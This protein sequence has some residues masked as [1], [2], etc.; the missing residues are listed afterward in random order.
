MP[1]YTSKLRLTLP[2]TGA[3]A[4]MWGDLV[5]TG[6]TP[7]IEDA[8]SGTVDID[9]SGAADYTLSTTN[10]DADESRNMFLHLIGTPGGTFNVVC[11]TVSK[12]YFVRNDTDAAQV[13]KTVA[14]SGVTVPLGAT[15]ALYCDGTDVLVAFNYTVSRE[16]PRVLS[17]T[18]YTTDTGTSLNCDLLD[19]FIVTAQAGALK[20]NNPTGTPT[21]AQA[22]FVAIT[23]TGAVALTYDTQ[24]EA[25]TTALPTTTV[26]TARLNLGFIWAAERSAWVLLGAV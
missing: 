8:I 21:D 5:N 17:D 7:L 15:M 2:T 24:F 1:S 14:G 13:L 23:G 12:L 16:I 4:G 11:P 22:L 20:L 6:I 19:A 26:G 25:S 9:L 18:N 3:S 10:G